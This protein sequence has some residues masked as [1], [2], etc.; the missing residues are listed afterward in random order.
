MKEDE[1][2]RLFGRRPDETIPSPRTSFYRNRMDYAVGPRLE[3]GLRERGKWWSFV[4]VTECLLQSPESNSIR[5]AFRDYI[6]REGLEGYDTKRHEGLVRYLVIREGKFTGERMAAVIT[7]R[8]A[9]GKLRGFIDEV[10]PIV[11]SYINGINPEMFDSS[12]AESTITISGDDRIEE[13]LLGYRFKIKVNS[14]FQTNS[15]TAEI[16]LRIVLEESR[17]SRKVYDLYS[18]VGTF[19]VPLANVVEEAYGVES[20]PESV[21]LARENARENGSS[22]TFYTARVESLGRLDA[23]TIVLDPP[24]AGVHPKALRLIGSSRPHRIIYVSCNPAKQAEDI[25][26]LKGYGIERLVMIDQ[27]PHTN[28]VET[29]AILSR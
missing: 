23:D 29:I 9:P 3:V 13:R 18:G 1:V 14:F 16:M 19:T 5:N 8:P 27:F 28:H 6:R 12:R 4:D 15:Y 20:D 24:R 10:G 17:G 21:E 26:R 25:K 11:N 22:P 2:S 7:S